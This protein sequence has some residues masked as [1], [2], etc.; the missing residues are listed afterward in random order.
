MAAPQSAIQNT[1]TTSYIYVNSLDRYS[2][3]VPPPAGSNQTTCTDITYSLPGLSNI[4]TVQ[5]SSIT[6]V[7]SWWNQVASNAFSSVF[8]TNIINLV[9][10]TTSTTYLITIP[11]GTGPLTTLIGNLGKYVQASAFG[12]TANGT[13][14]FTT[15]ASVNGTYPTY[16]PSG[17][18]GTF[19]VWGD[20]ARAS[21]Q[22][23]FGWSRVTTAPD[24]TNIA[25]RRQLFDL[26][27]L[28]GHVPS[29]A[30]LPISTGAGYT[31]I[32]FNPTAG[33]LQGP[34]RFM[35]MISPQITNFAP[36]V[37]SCATASS[38]AIGRYA[39]VGINASQFAAAGTTGK[40]M[41][42]APGSTSLRLQLVDDQQNPLP[43][44]FPVPVPYA[45]AL[46]TGTGI[47]SSTLSNLTFSGITTAS[48]TFPTGTQVNILT[49]TGTATGWNPGVYQ[50][51]SS[52]SST[53]TIPY[54]T[55]SANQIS[56]AA[57]TFSIAPVWQ[58]T[59][60]TNQCGPEYQMTLIGIARTTTA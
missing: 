60:S 30:G 19:W 31:T 16:D 13:L 39:G 29:V 58:Y 46:P 42:V 10:L 22:H 4:A 50:V 28:A 59:T 41:K 15:S 38:N 56:N 55:T 2:N 20:T 11:E 6:P 5:V 40:V 49:L 57:Y 53:V 1:P 24:G 18:S 32:P 23:S 33:P 36:D 9:D 35:D 51:Q 44:N 25:N 8:Y 54:I 52:T 47:L 48:T 34:I 43:T 17:L 7:S 14:S 21:S 12:G 27:G 37:N 26:L 3:G 45:G